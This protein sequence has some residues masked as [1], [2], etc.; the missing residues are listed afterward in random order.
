M[1]IFFSDEGIQHRLNKLFDLAHQGLTK[2][3]KGLIPL[4]MN[5]VRIDEVVYEGSDEHITFFQ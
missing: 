5:R 3:L 1:M 4:C 2:K